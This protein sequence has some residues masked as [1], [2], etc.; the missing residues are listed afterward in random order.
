MASHRKE[1]QKYKNTIFCPDLQQREEYGFHKTK[2]VVGKPIIDY[3]TN[4]RMYYLKD[5]KEEIV[6]T[7]N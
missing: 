6:I 5:I 7:R 3:R 1:C 2:V 4:S